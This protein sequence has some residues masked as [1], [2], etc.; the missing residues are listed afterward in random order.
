M[1]ITSKNWMKEYYNYNGNGGYFVYD[2]LINYSFIYTTRKRNHFNYE[3][4]FTGF[5]LICG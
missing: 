3:Y 4:H 2:S 1:W 5:Y